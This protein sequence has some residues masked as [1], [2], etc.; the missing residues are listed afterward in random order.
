MSY[1]AAGTWVEIGIAALAAGGAGYSA[2]S[3]YEQGQNASALARYN[4]NQTAAANQANLQASASKSLAERQQN[5]KILAQ[6]QAAFAAAGVVT[7]SGSPLTVETKQAALLERR[8]LNTDYEGAIAYRYGAGQVTQF[9]MQGDAAKQA[10][11]LTAAGTL[12]SGAG[13]AASSYYKA[14]NGAGLGAKK[15]VSS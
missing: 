14:G 12:L 15:T 9:N 8:A 2:Y 1:F 13:N 5:E 3:S 6:Q 10:G 7:N 4:A 11:N